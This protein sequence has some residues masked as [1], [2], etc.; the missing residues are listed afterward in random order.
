VNATIFD[1]HNPSAAIGDTF[2]FDVVSHLGLIDIHPAAGIS[3]LTFDVSTSLIAG[4]RF[5]IKPDY[6]VADNSNTK[7]KRVVDVVEN[8]NAANEVTAA[9]IHGETE[10]FSTADYFIVYASSGLKD[11]SSEQQCFGVIGKEATATSSGNIIYVTDGDGI[12]N[13]MYA[14]FLTGTSAANQILSGTTV[15]SVTSHSNGVEVTLSSNV[16]GT[17]ESGATIVFTPA[18]YNNDNREYCVLPLNTAP[19]FAGTDEGLAT[20]T[21]Y[22]NLKVNGLR[23]TNLYL[24]NTSSA[25]NTDT[26]YSQYLTVSYN[27]TDYKALIK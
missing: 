12:V 20:T 7:F 27:G 11:L 15:S 17:I 8:N 6:L 16:Q 3:G 5:E 25:D 19:P 23:F 14:Q 22:P 9:I 26:S 24:N 21:T 1:Y 4:N 2:T 10:N 13:G 18:S